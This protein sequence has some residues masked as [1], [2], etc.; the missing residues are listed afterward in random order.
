MNII[1]DVIKKIADDL[2]IDSEDITKESLRAFLREKRRKIKIDILEILDRYKVSSSR[3]LEEKI[4]KGEVS[5]HPTW[6][7]L[8][9]LENLEETLKIIEENIRDIP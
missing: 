1:E 4:F 7:D 2:G 9:L 8:I 5:E 6:E 3:E